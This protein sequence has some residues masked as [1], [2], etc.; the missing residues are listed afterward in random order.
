MNGDGTRIV[1]VTCVP[2]G[3][4][5]PWGITPDGRTI[6]IESSGDLVP[7]SNSDLGPELYLMRLR[8]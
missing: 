6:S 3:F 4:T 1:Q 7:G 2:G 5:S 8:P